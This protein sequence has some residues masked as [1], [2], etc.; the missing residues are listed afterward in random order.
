MKRT[1]AGG[2]GVECDGRLPERF[3][4]LGETSVCRSG[5]TCE[6]L[7]AYNS[8]IGPQPAAHDAALAGRAP[9]GLS[10]CG[11]R[12][13]AYHIVGYD[14]SNPAALWASCGSGLYDPCG[15]YRW[16]IRQTGPPVQSSTESSRQDQSAP[17][18]GQPCRSRFAVNQYLD[19]KTCHFS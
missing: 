14:R 6:C 5:L 7:E 10:A 4:A 13:P 8:V 1:P 11:N 16:D 3:C 12:A 19:C 9:R 15:R 17:P 18:I 2:A